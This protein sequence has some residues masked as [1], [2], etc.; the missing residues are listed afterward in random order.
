[1]DRNLFGL[2][3]SLYQTLFDCIPPL[4]QILLR[5]SNVDWYKRAGKAVKAT[6]GDQVAEVDGILQPL[7]AAQ[8]SLQQAFSGLVDE[9]DAST[10]R[11]VSATQKEVG[12]VR[13]NQYQHHHETLEEMRSVVKSTSTLD[14]KVDVLVDRIERLELTCKE[15]VLENPIL[16]SLH[17]LT[18][19]LLRKRQISESKRSLLLQKHVERN[20]TCLQPTKNMI[21]VSCYLTQ[22]KKIEYSTSTTFSPRSTMT[23]KQQ[24]TAKTCTQH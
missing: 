17:I 11:L 19:E 5:D 12:V 23:R 15:S 4:I 6:L 22:I 24:L 9:K 3:T 14:N 1:M 18:A 20:L 2:V 16:N 21:F 13:R 10:A 8:R 7:T